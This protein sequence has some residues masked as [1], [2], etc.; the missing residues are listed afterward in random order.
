MLL[1]LLDLAYGSTCSTC[2]L[3]CG[4]LPCG[5]TCAL[6]CGSTC[7]T[8]RPWPRTGLWAR[9]SRAGGWRE[10]RPEAQ[11]G[12]GGM[13][14]GDEAQL[15]HGPEGAARRTVEGESRAAGGG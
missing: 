1:D 13:Y 11:R 8:P 9:R 5:S 7:A 2:V 15:A 10:R 14:A 4:V 3:T 12:D 6:T